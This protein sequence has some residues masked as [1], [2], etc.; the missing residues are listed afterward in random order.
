[1]TVA[2][3]KVTVLLASGDEDTWDDVEDAVMNMEAGGA[4]TVIGSDKNVA[5]LYAPGMWMKVEYD[6]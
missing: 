3:H 5:A 1:M 4:L 2:L 6:Q